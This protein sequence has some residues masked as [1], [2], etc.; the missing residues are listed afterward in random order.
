[1]TIKEELEKR[2]NE[3]GKTLLERTKEKSAKEWCNSMEDGSAII[4][5]FGAIGLI[6]AVIVMIVL[7]S[8]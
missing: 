1:M 3:T 7:C 6:V 5:I 8:K 4:A 2:K